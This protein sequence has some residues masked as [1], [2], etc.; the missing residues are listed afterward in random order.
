MLSS[1]PIDISYLTR[2]CEALSVDLESLKGKAQSLPYTPPMLPG[3]DGDTVNNSRDRWTEHQQLRPQRAIR[4][5]I[6]RKQSIRR[7]DIR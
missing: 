1:M 5:W 7:D 2:D 3:D 4:A 6:R